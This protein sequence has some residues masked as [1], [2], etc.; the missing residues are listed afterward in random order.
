MYTVS[1]AKRYL[2]LTLT[3]LLVFISVTQKVSSQQIPD[4]PI[5]SAATNSQEITTCHP[6]TG[7]RWTDGPS[8]PGMADQ[9]EQVLDQL[10]IEAFVEAKSF[11]ETD[12]CGTFRLYTVDFTIAI[13]EH[14]P[15]NDTNQQEL[16]NLVYSVLTDYGK[17]NLGN[18]KIAL[19]QGDVIYFRGETPG[20]TVPDSQFESLGTTSLSAQVD[21]HLPWQDTG[22]FI[23]ANNTITAEVI[24]GLW[25]HQVGVAP[26]NNG[27]GGSYTCADYYPPNDCVEPMPEVPQGALIGK[28]GSHL[29]AIGSGT[30]V[31]TQQSG[32]LYLRMNDG[33][34]GLY[35]N[36]GA[37][38]V[39]INTSS[40]SLKYLRN[41]YVVVYDPLLSNGQLL[42]EYLNWAKH[43]DMT[44]EAIDFFYQASNGR[45]LY[46]V[47][48][49]TVVTSGWPEKIDGYQ[50]TEEE[51]LNVI[52]GN[53]PAHSPD[54]VDYN[55]IVNDPN[56]DICGRVN[57]GEIDEIWI[58]NGPWF[59]FGESTLVGP[60]A[61]WYNS[62]PVPEPHTCNRLVPIMGPS[63]ERTGLTG[64][65]EGHR[66]ESTMYRVYGSWQQ[67][68]TNHNWERFALVDAQSPD[69]SYSGCGSIH[70]PPNGTSDY[71]Y[72][73][74]SIANTNCDD[75]NNY[76]NLG[77]PLITVEPVSCSTWG[78]DHY[79]YMMYW[80]SHLPSNSGCGPDGM[81]NDWWEY[82]VEPALALDPSSPCYEFHIYL[83]GIVR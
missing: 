54:T 51:Y 81:A 47:V 77:D 24:S 14:Y 55:K 67:N 52:G 31:T 78:C 59:G 48:D 25:T 69:Y 64:H 21:A 28:I 5:S 82:F 30:I 10:G 4:S 38:T 57:R 44:Q 36:D 73:N 72:S 43:V 19:P 56:L 70:Y 45:L 8:K 6:G 26:Y 37:L 39:D 60:N 46:T 50:Y 58:Y 75:F 65:G 66:M 80:F 79:G 41:V 20:L 9:V 12:S 29:F 71:D 15:V 11:G 23:E 13:D 42:S 62:P 2:V 32:N 49:T 34:D 83:P 22:L 74:P 35:D 33:D 7:W 53:S 17:P 1:F 3:L 16:A 76:P 40:Q 68:R 63:P 27:V 61:Y 18:V